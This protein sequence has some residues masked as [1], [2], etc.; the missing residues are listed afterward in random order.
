MGDC[1][2]PFPSYLTSVCFVFQAAV[3]GREGFRPLFYKW[4][5]VGGAVL[6]RGQEVFDMTQGFHSIRH[7]R[8]CDGPRSELMSLVV[9]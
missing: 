3:G 9:E 1:L 8:F 2:V 4:D 5:M 7:L 6:L